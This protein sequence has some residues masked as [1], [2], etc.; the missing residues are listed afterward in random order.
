MEDYY[1]KQVYLPHFSSYHRQ[2][3]SGIGALAAGIGRIALPFAKK[4]I[5]PAAKSIGKELF[6]QSVP[7]V[8][9][10]IAKRK[11]PRQAAKSAVKKTVKK[12][13]GG[14]SRVTRNR[15]IKPK[16]VSRKSKRKQRSRSDFFSNV[17][18]VA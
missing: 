14:K 3:G 2:R 11:S 17:K 16:K 6:V 5:L 12:Q 15:K 8:L 9:D 7:E 1:A 13:I 4:F 18:N 10:V